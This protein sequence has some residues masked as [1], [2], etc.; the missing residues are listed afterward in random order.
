MDRGSYIF[1]INGEDPPHTLVVF[2]TGDQLSPLFLD[3]R[4]GDGL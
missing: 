4:M 1:A 3:S 2:L